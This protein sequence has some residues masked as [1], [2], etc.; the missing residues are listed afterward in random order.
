[1]IAFR[2]ILRDA[3][4]VGIAAAAA[5][6]YVTIRLVDALVDALLSIFNGQRTSTFEGAAVELPWHVTVN[7]RIVFLM[8]VVQ[9]LLVFLVTAAIVA[10]ALRHAGYDEAV[11][12]P[13]A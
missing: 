13:V 1:V 6:A 5:L 11:E 7:G 3:W 4:A 8:P 12:P 10:L 9:A 2:A